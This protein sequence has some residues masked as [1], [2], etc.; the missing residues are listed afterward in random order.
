MGRRISLMVMVFSLKSRT[1][2]RS[3]KVC[4]P[5]IGSYKG[6]V[7][8]QEYS[9]ISGHKWTLLL[10]EYSMNESS[11]SPTFLVLKV[12]LEVLQDLGT[13]FFTMGMYLL[14]PFFML[15]R[16]PLNPVSRK[17]LIVLLLTNSLMLAL[18]G[19]RR[20]SSRCKLANLDLF[21]ST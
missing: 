1:A 17:T 20:S 21:P 7:P 15:R 4:F 16:S 11:M 8:P 10:A 14:D 9:T 2:P 19:G 3:C 13:A 5:T 12:P 18:S 6:G